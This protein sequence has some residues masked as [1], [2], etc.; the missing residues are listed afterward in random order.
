MA[1]TSPTVMCRLNRLFFLVLVS[2]APVQFQPVALDVVTP[3]NERMTLSSASSSR[4]W[5]LM[6]LP[7]SDERTCPATWTDVPSTAMELERVEVIPMV[8]VPDL[9]SGVTCPAVEPSDSTTR[10]LVALDVAV[11]LEVLVANVGFAT[12]TG[13][14]AREGLATVTAATPRAPMRTRRNAG[15]WPMRVSFC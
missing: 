9:D 3:A 11:Q 13:S 7:G 5:K 10:F 14:A 15:V 1:V 4:S 12:M 8:F 6:V 2:V